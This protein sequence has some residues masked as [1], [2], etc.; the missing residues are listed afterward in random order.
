VEG[1]G[2][3]APLRALLGVEIAKALI[4]AGRTAQDRP[5]PS[6]RSGPKHLVPVANRPILFHNLEALRR[7]GVLEATIA[8]EPESAEPIMAAVGDGSAWSLSVRY[9]EWLPAS[10]VGGALTAAREFLADEP[11]LVGPGDALHRDQIHPHIAAFADRQ[12]DAMALRLSGAPC[13]RSGT[14]FPGGYLLSRRGISILLERPMLAGDPMAG[15]RRRGGQVTVQDVDGCLACHGGQDSLLDGNRRLLEDLQGN[16]EATSYPSCQ[17]QGPVMVHPSARLDHTLVRGPAIIGPEARLSHAYVGPYTSIGAG[18]TIDGSQIEHSI[19]LDG[20]ELLHVGSR[21]ESSVI[22]RG[23]RI[24]RSFGVPT[25]MRLAV[26]D[27]AE[28]TIT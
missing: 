1:R 10:G 17:F 7:A 4:L 13:D 23:A 8:L 26:G 19:V 3:T 18:V 16:V 11:V 12:L 24:T 6:V 2:E 5:W 25:A 28:V 22:G 21:L 14:P 9:V 20:A 15:I 27:G